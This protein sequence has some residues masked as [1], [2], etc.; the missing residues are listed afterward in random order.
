M[1]I[2]ITII[3]SNLKHILSN[4]VIVYENEITFNTLSAIVAEFK[5]VFTN[6]KNIINLSEDQ[7]I[8]IS[9][10]ADTIIKSFKVYSLNYKNREVIDAIFNKL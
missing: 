4:R 5:D 3:D 8:S 7:W 9:L 1:N 10:K 2:I 6:S